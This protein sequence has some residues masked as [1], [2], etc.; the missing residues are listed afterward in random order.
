M[1]KFINEHPKLYWMIVVI[2][3]VVVFAIVTCIGLGKLE[4]V[5]AAERVELENMLT[6]QLRSYRNESKPLYAYL[7]YVEYENGVERPY[8]CVMLV[9]GYEETNFCFTTVGS[10]DMLFATFPA[11]ALNDNGRVVSVEQHSLS[12]RDG[13]SVYDVFYLE[14]NIDFEQCD[15]PSY[16]R[17]VENVSEFPYE[18]S[19]DAPYSVFDT[20]GH[21]NKLL[22]GDAKGNVLKGLYITHTAA[23]KWAYGGKLVNTSSDDISYKVLMD[24]TVEIPNDTLINFIAE[25][26]DVNLGWDHDVIKY[27]PTLIEAWNGYTGTDYSTYSFHMELPCILDTSGVRWGYNV[28]FIDT[29]YF[30]MSDDNFRQRF[31]TYNSDDDLTHWKAIVLAFM[32]IKKVS[33]VIETTR[34][35]SVVYGYINA[36][37]FERGYERRY[38]T[39]V[40]I[41]KD[42]GTPEFTQ[43]AINQ[44][45]G[46]AKNQHIIDMENRLDEMQNQI[47][48]MQNFQGSFGTDLNGSDLWNG[49]KSLGSGLVGLTSF[50]SNISLVIGDLFVFLPYDVR[51][52]AGYFFMATL[53]VALWKLIKR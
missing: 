13:A 42:F 34:A 36:T 22:N 39:T 17:F 51:Q 23:S 48:E 6:E 14:G 15:V 46:V 7:G 4:K 33:T 10:F 8:R 47:D 24:V 28:P 44:E 5:E 30:L 31:Q 52:I 50:L 27:M 38:S 11:V 53:L 18:Y 1:K 43:S 20:F 16:I 26:M 49:I 32:H 25:Q 3:S 9:E 45:L 35:D 41:D 2:L 29:E 21:D 19:S 12:D 37:G 40:K